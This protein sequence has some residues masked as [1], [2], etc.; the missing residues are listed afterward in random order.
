[1][2]W[3]QLHAIFAERR[4]FTLCL[5]RL[6]IFMWL[7]FLAVGLILGT[8]GFSEQIHAQTGRTTP[9]S[10]PMP[11]MSLAGQVLD[12]ATKS[13]VG[14]AT[15][16]VVR[17]SDSVMVGGHMAKEDGTFVI[18]RLTAGRYLIKCTF[19]GYKTAWAGPITLSAAGPFAQLGALSLASQ[20]S[21]LKE[22]VIEGERPI[23]QLGIDRKTFDVARSNLTPGGTAIDVLATVPTV[24]V[25]VD[26]NVSMRNSDNITIYIDGRPSGI[27]ASN[28]AMILKQIPANAI[29]RIE[30]ITS[31]S[32]RYDA[33]GSGGIINIILKK[34]NLEGFNGSVQASIGTRQKYNLSGNVAYRNSWVNTFVNYNLRN[35]RR[36]GFGDMARSVRTLD[37]ATGAY[38]ETFRSWATNQSVN[39]DRGQF[40][41]VGADFT[42]PGKNTLGISASGNPSI[43]W[44]KEENGYLFYPGNSETANDSTRR[45]VYAVNRADNYDF[46]LTHIKK[47]ET[48]GHEWS[49]QANFSHY[50]NRNVTEADQTGALAR[51]GEQSF[52][53]SA[54]QLNPL[55]NRTKVFTAQTDYVHPL[56]KDKK[57]E[58]GAKSTARDIFNDQKFFAGPNSNNTTAVAVQANSFAYNELIAAA[59]GVWQ[60]KLGKVGYQAGLRYEQTYLNNRF[61][62]E[63]QGSRF[64]PRTYGYLI[65]TVNVNYTAN[66]SHEFQVSYAQRLNRPGAGQLN[67]FVDYSDPTTLRVGNPYMDPERIHALEGNWQ[68]N[69]QAVSL[70]STAFYRYNQNLITRVIQVTSD[71]RALVTETNSGT[72][73]DAGSEFTGRW[74]IKKGYSLTGNTSL[75]YSRIQ[76]PQIS[77]GIIRDN[78][79]YAVRLTAQ[80]QLAPMLQLQATTFYRSPFI[81]PQGSSRAFYNTDL[82]ITQDF[83]K[84]RASISLAVNDIFNTLRF[85]IRTTD[86]TFENR[87]LRKRETQ[88]ATLA[89]S[90]RFGS[91][92]NLSK[93]REMRQNGG[94]DM[95]F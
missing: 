85:R 9:E 71:G 11:G 46:N 65:P 86:F 76:A 44:N 49:T 7:R 26:G 70:T 75:F 8:L 78:I 36:T 13:P 54:Y 35:F 82:A 2:R 45:T 15:V 20:A 94:G 59:Y 37:A 67:P 88:I 24:T 57:F 60:Q 90:Y 53:N 92:D 38:P 89:L 17:A 93:K 3:L 61:T 22:V 84:K 25:D 51:N 6:E 95:S 31:P 4:M 12:S 29:E 14:F 10:G 73:K 77:N 66:A 1:M 30:L 68:W 47:F 63:L 64:T 18:D 40:L 55:T 58:L 16:A 74:Q 83:Y 41:K 28:R 79:N 62:Q 80:A 43:N 69:T 19:I 27:T 23:F 87:M 33:E 52:I 34:N 42:L 50:A 48:Q 32:A 5:L 56:G 91:L 81:L 39:T 72:R 21:R